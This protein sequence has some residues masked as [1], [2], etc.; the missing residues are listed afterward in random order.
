MTTAA[1]DDPRPTPPSDLLAKLP[2][3]LQQ[4]VLRRLGPEDFASLA[5][6][7]RGCA[8]AVA[9]TAIM[10][11]AKNEKRLRRGPALTLKNACFKAALGGNLEVLEWLHDAGAPWDVHTCAI[12][13][14]GGHLE[15]LQWLR[16]HGCPW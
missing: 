10:K 2:D 15:A 3:L 5:R 1:P 9:A 14:Y 4:K 16:A 7:G 12:A 11:W 13:A 8:A 6:A